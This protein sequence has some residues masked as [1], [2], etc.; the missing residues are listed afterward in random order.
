MAWSSK[1]EKEYQKIR[2]QTM[3]GK[4]G[5]RTDKIHEKGRLTARERLS[6]LFDGQQYAELEM[7]ARSRSDF[8]EIEKTHWLV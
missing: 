6:L 8:G 7:Y 3:E 5:E 2:M 4:G 1:R